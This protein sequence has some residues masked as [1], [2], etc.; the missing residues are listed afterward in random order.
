MQK[1]KILIDG[2]SPKNEFNSCNAAA[3]SLMVLTVSSTLFTIRFSGHFHIMLSAHKFCKIT[4]IYAGNQ[5]S[6]R[7]SSI[8]STAKTSNI[9]N[10]KSKQP[11]LTNPRRHSLSIDKVYNITASYSTLILHEVEVTKLVPC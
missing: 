4:A 5:C 7:L 6:C 10:T 2:P 9:L 8:S 11:L 3:D 1:F